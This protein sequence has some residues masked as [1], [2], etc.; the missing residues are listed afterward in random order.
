MT[1]APADFSIAAPADL[2]TAALQAPRGNQ[3]VSRRGVDLLTQP[4]LNKGTAFSD[5]ER[6]VFGLRGLLP[7]HVSTIDEQVALELEHIRRKPDDLERFIGLAALRERNETLF[8]R[9]LVENLEEMLPVVYTPTVGRACQEFSHILRRPR[10]IWLTPDDVGRMEQILAAVG[11][12]IRLIVVTDNER[13]LGLGDL[14]AGGMGIPIGKLSIYTAAAGIHPSHTL[15]VSL[16]VGTDRTELLSD[17]LYLGYRAPRLRGAAYDAVLE[18]FV[19]AVVHVHPRAVIQWED[20]KQHNAVRV[21]ERHRHRIPSFNDDIQGTGAVVLAG[22]LAGRSERGGLAGE[23][24]LMIGAGAAGLGITD[25]VRRQMIAEGLPADAAAA[26]TILVDSQG[27]VHA[28]R[29]GLPA[30]KRAFA[31]DGAAVA[32][33]GITPDQLVDVVAIA[34]AFRPTIL[35][36]TSGTAGR[37]TAEL[38]AEVAR[39][40]PEPIVMPLSNPSSK[41]EAT[42]EQILDW[43]DGRALVA[44]GSP[45]D[46]VSIDGRTRIIGQG[47]NA[48]IFPGVGLGAIVAEAR[49]IPDEFFLVAARVLASR[50]PAER[51]A[52][53]A[54]Y[55][56]IAEM[57]SVS[58]E[59]AVEVV[60][61]AR[62]RGYGRLYRDEDIE[63]AVDRA[64]WTPDYLPFEPA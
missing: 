60:R 29:P 38:V 37:F 41:T 16:D 64:M 34:A 19:E 39:H 45:F 32:A 10:G 33:L 24:M 44:T 36:G 25:A 48:F 13:I 59:I 26:A 21:L 28:G 4:L 2:A 22:L 30:D 17:S 55:P 56:P 61:V 14:G 58:R 31:L 50:V 49:S 43:T 46:P 18:A 40:D 63:S 8:Y 15:P 5:H 27:L 1:A 47:N 53:G 54:L 7:A 9:L 6:D 51:R 23:R 3:R 20:F 11:G 57:R 62:D 42:P 35:A 52:T 12:D